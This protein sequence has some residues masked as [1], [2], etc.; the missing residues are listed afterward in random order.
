MANGSGIKERKKRQQLVHQ[1]LPLFPFSWQDP[2]LYGRSNYQTV[3]CTR[4]M[5]PAGLTGHLLV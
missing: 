1:S 5:D 2:S 3:V 4:D